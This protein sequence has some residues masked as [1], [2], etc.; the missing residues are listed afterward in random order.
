MRLADEPVFMADTP[1]KKK[2]KLLQLRVDSDWLDRLKEAADLSGI[3]VSA[4]V[5][6]A[7]TQRM[8]Q[9]NV[10]RRNKKRKA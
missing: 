5:R 9:E 10:P 3:G 7:C 8:N 2:G 4:Y 6:L 1:K